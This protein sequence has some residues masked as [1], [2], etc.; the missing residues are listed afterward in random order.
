MI[1]RLRFFDPALNEFERWEQMVSTF[2]L[3]VDDLGEEQEQRQMHWLF[4]N[5][6]S[7]L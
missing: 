7:E 4:R 6:L 3:F 1:D 5:A 2:K